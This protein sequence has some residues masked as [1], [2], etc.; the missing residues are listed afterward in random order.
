MEKLELK[1]VIFYPDKIIFLRKKSNITVFI[2][3]ICSI[4]YEKPNFWNYFWAI[5]CFGGTFPGRLEIYLNKKINRRKLYFV[6]IKFE[7]IYKLPEF[8][9]EAIRI[10]RF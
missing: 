10:Q 8:Y 1:K 2:K 5:P 9:K 6:N 3:D 7:D 4:V